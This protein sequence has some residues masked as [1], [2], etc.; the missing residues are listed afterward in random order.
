M[1]SGTYMFHMYPPYASQPIAAV[2]LKI[3]NHAIATE[4]WTDGT[5]VLAEHDAPDTLKTSNRAQ[6]VPWPLAGD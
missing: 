5:P 3:C 2:K 1:E 6:L 4:D